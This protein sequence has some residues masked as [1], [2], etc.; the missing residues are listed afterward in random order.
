MDRA[1]VASKLDLIRRALLVATEHIDVLRDGIAAD[2]VDAIVRGR[3]G[4]YN[5]LELCHELMG[6]VEAD[7]PD[8]RPHPPA[9]PDGYSGPV[10]R[11]DPNAHLGATE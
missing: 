3:V 10:P 1:L 4:Y 9:G 5:G 2:D 11:P 6:E 7:C 8:W